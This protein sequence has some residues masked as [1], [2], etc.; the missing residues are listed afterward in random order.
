MAVDKKLNIL[1]GI[2]KGISQSYLGAFNT[3]VNLDVN[4]SPGIVYP[5]WKLQ[6]QFPHSN[7]FTYEGYAF[8]VDVDTNE[9]ISTSDIDNY[10]DYGQAIRFTT[11]T[12]LPA[13]LSTNTTYYKD[14]GSTS[15]KIKVATTLKNLADGTYVD[16]TGSGTGTHT[17][18]ARIMGVAKNIIPLF[19]NN[20][21]YT[22]AAI[23]DNNRVWILNS[24][25]SAW[26]E[27]PGQ[28]SGS[29]NGIAYWKNYLI[30]THYDGLNPTSAV[31]AYG[32]IAS[33]WSTGTWNNNF[34]QISSNSYASLV[35]MSNDILYI[36]AD[37]DVSS[38]EEVVGETFLP[39][40]T[41]TFIFSASALDLPTNENIYSL[42]QLGSNLMI[43]TG[44]TGVGKI[45]PW[46]T[47]SPSFGEPVNTN[48]SIVATMISIDG[49]LYFIDNYWGTIY[50]TNGSTVQKIKDFSESSL[51]IQ[52]IFQLNP[53][54]IS[55]Y[56]TSIMRMKDKILFGV[57]GG[58]AQGIYAYNIST[59]ALTLAFKT[60][61]EYNGTS[62]VL[63]YA[64]CPKSAIDFYVSVY[65]QSITGSNY[66]NQ[67]QTLFL[68][69]AYKPLS[70]W[71]ETGLFTVGNKIQP[72]T[73]RFFEIELGKELSAGEVVT[74]YYRNNLTDSF[75][76]IGTM[77]YAD[78]GAIHSKVIENSSVS[79]DQIQFKV[80][81]TCGS[82]ATTGPEIKAIYI[83]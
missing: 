9:I 73:Y 25:T 65:D 24:A 23:D 67:I 82:S 27:L 4:S 46:D 38:L 33:D 22:H 18:T 26:M 59:G 49:I 13:G 79:G 35:I 29:I 68:S 12:T 19:I 7:G 56:G 31:D 1:E 41:N 74:I 28:G 34:A 62:T 48:L 61:S 47:I 3:V 16:I 58:K 20:S 63:F 72:T 40:D 30:V 69:S 77:S 57:G 44:G 21:L 32:P 60:A 76:T 45:Y 80:L 51:G 70:S 52:Q 55:L 75:T 81:I 53:I 54:T 17:V 50:A 10:Y 66:D 83:Y 14:S 6:Q 43:G 71:F 8:T 37:N 5:Q 15:K 11:T 39:S 42:A 78:D 64:M 36:G 2:E